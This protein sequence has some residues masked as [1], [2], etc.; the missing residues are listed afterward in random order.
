MKQTDSEQFPYGTPKNSKKDKTDDL[1][2]EKDENEELYL[3]KRTLSPD[4]MAISADAK[5]DS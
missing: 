2:V 4:S 5:Y 1:L 3:E